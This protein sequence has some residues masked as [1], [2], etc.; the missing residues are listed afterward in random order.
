MEY[1]KRTSLSS[2][3]QSTRD[4]WLNFLFSS[5]QLFNTHFT[6]TAMP[7]KLLVSLWF[8]ASCTTT[9]HI[10]CYLHL[11]LSRLQ[12]KYVVRE[13]KALA[14][15]FGIQKHWMY[16]KCRK[17]CIHT[18]HSSSQW[19]FSSNQ[20]NKQPRLWW[21]CF[22]LQ[23]YNF[24]AKYIIL[25]ALNHIASSTT[26]NTNSKENLDNYRT[27]KFG[28]WVLTYQNATS[29]SSWLR[30]S[31]QDCL[32]GWYLVLNNVLLD[33]FYEINHNTSNKKLNNGSI[34]MIKPNHN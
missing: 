19:L 34:T 2:F 5:Y 24:E 22:F 6:F 8:Y 16:F 4:S 10:L 21:W 17:F 25:G 32:V 26:R 15:M 13:L 14:I 7:S 33:H 20:D 9:L 28:D 18:Y 27:Y 29:L 31:P 11:M 12:K 3:S 1:K 23:S 30:K